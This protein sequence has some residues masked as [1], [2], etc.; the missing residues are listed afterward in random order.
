MSDAIPKVVA[1]AFAPTQRTI[2]GRILQPLS[3]AHYVALARTNNAFVQNDRPLDVLEAG[4]AFFL[5]S[6]SG[7]EALAAAGAPDFD[8]RV[9][10]FLAA[11]PV[12]EALE[13]TRVVAEHVNA[14]FA[15]ALA[16][17]GKDGPPPLAASAGG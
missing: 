2:A 16:G 7:E 1:E 14:A 4:R 9:G 13:L 11:I 5:L 6:L 10:A 15:P 8:A 17:E 3:L 12:A